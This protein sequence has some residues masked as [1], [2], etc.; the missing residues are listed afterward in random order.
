MRS[1]WYPNY[2][3][4][5]IIFALVIFIS[6]GGGWFLCFSYPEKAYLLSSVYLLIFAAL[7]LTP[8]IPISADFYCFCVYYL[9]PTCHIRSLYRTLSIPVCRSRASKGST[10]TLGVDDCR[11]CDFL[12][13]LLNSIFLYLSLIFFANSSILKVSSSAFLSC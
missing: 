9:S 10:K 7:S 12:S 2:L 4:A 6:C 3:L 8:F 13:S 5:I 11:D 1:I